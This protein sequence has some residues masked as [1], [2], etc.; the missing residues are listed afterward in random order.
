MQQMMSPDLMQSHF[1]FLTEHLVWLVVY[2]TMTK[3]RNENKP[4][5]MQNTLDKT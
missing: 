3:E 4:D 2:L 1:Y 5:L